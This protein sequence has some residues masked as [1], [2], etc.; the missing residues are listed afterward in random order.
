MKQPSDFSDNL[1]FNLGA[2]AA[3]VYLDNISL[4]NPPVGDLNLDGHVDFLDLGIYG[5]NWLKQ[6]SGLPGDLDGNNKVDFTD[7]GILGEN[8]SGGH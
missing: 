5:G 4:F 3:Y 7:F 6:Q 2:S 1:I 8:W